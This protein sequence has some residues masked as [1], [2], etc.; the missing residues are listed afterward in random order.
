MATFEEAFDVVS[1]TFQIHSLNAQQKTGIWKIEAVRNELLL[2][3]DKGVIDDEEFVLLWDCNKSKNAN[4]SYEDYANLDLD[5]IAEAKCKTEFRVEK[6]ILETLLKSY[7]SPKR[8]QWNR[9]SLS[10]F[11]RPSVSMQV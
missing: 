11:E 1:N 6:L 9:G 8:L 2:T 10:C 3:Y 5:C 4:F 7:R